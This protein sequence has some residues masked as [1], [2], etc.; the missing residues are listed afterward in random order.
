MNCSFGDGESSL[1]FVPAPQLQ[2]SLQ[3]SLS[4][5][6]YGEPPDLDDQM[7]KLSPI[8]HTTTPNSEHLFLDAIHKQGVALPTDRSPYV[9]SAFSADERDNL[10]LMHHYTRSAYKSISGS[11]EGLLVWRD[12]VP[13]LALEHDFILHGLLAVS[14]LH[15]A[16]SD[17][18]H[19]PAHSSLALRHYAAG[20]V[21]F[22][23]H[24]NTVTPGNV[25][26]LF[27]FACLVSL[28]A[29]GLPHTSHSPINALLEIQEVFT[30]N[31]GVAV[32]V[33][34]GSEWLEQGPFRHLLLPKPINP[35][36]PL[37]FEVEDALTA[38]AKRN[39]EQTT[40]A[41]LRNVYARA[42]GILRHCFRLLEERPGLSMTV[43]PFPITVEPEFPIA[44]AERKPM[45][46]AILAHY[47]VVLHRL[48]GHVW[49]KGWG[50]EVVDSIEGAV[51]SEWQECIAWPIEE[52]KKSIDEVPEVTAY[53][54]SE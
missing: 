31:R 25:S 50:R 35:W 51:G 39:Y 53:Y 13:Q 21:L 20:L 37:S 2:E 6:S 27:T 16:L 23:P 52:V 45:A 4:T 38:L 28:Y 9:A 5:L 19:P 3:P 24:L 29:W 22:Y 7:G 1:L 26:S 46:L 14:S 17:P 49:L 34:S 32:I 30:L 44:M 36:K 40:D 33:R 41:R 8:Y 54:E 43:L 10:R 42:I 12:L 47:G 15:L 11:V 18:T 48:G